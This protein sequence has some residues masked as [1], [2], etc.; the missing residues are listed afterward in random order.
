MKKITDYSRLH[1]KVIQKKFSGGLE[2]GSKIILI[3]NKSVFIY[4][5]FLL[6]SPFLWE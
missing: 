2:P 5:L 6:F 1:L 4:A 3:K